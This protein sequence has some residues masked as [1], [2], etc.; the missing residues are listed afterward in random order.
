MSKTRPSVRLSSTT[1][2]Q[3]Q[4]PLQNNLSYEHTLATDRI[5]SP[6]ILLRLSPSPLQDTPR[7]FALAVSRPHLRRRSFGRARRWLV[8]GMAALSGPVES[9]IEITIAVLGDPA[10]GH[11]AAVWPFIARP[12][13]H[14]WAARLVMMIRVEWM[15]ERRR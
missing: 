11:V 10:C 2:C 7:T 8:S 4:S 13:A 6:T 15:N 12:G 14:H 1:Q 5:S 3:S 9:S